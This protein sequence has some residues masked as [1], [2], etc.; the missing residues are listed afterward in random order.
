MIFKLSWK[1]SNDILIIVPLFSHLMS[2]ILDEMHSSQC[3]CAFR[4]MGAVARQFF[5]FMYQKI[6]C[7]MKMS[8]FKN[9]RDSVVLKFL[10][11]GC[12]QLLSRVRLCAT[13]TDWNPPGSSVHE[14]FQAR[15]M[16]WVVISYS[17]RPFHPKDRTH[18]S[19]VSCI[20]SQI[21]YHWAT[22][23]APWMMSDPQISSDLLGKI[24]GRRRREQQRMR[25]L[26]GI[27]NSVDLNL[28]RLQEIVKNREAWCA[29]V[30]GG[31]RIRHDLATEQQQQKD[32]SMHL[33]K[34]DCEKLK[35][36][37]FHIKLRTL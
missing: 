34:N 12:A 31:A 21:L 30:H 13:P 1:A 2:N 37:H 20:D 29:V 14:I 19:C 6:L 24:E 4:N 28:S 7:Y 11:D 15:I 32:W 17:R 27:T 22:W 25:W 36:Y 33:T 26:D 16:E 18:I 10:N 23:E 5:I 8:L 35:L 3:S 9:Y